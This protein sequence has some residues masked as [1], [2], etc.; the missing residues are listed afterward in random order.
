ME[1]EDGVS[2]AA[3]EARRSGEMVD[4]VGGEPGAAVSSFLGVDP[5]LC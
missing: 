3:A 5:C 1:N 4:V 2:V